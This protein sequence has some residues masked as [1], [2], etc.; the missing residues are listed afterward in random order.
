MLDVYCQEEIERRERIVYENSDW[1]VV[2]PYWATWP[3]QV[4]LL[5]KFRTTKMKNF[6]HDQKKTFAAALIKLTTKYDNLFKCNFPYSMGFYESPNGDNDEHWTFH[7][8]FYPPLLR[9]ASVRKFMV[10]FCQQD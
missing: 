4:L 5:P 1:I 10:S 9:S 2:V 3:Y 6:T 8:H 7:A